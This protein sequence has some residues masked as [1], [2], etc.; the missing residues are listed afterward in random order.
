[1]TDLLPANKAA[2]L[3]HKHR[4]R[5]LDE[6]H[7]VLLETTNKYILQACH[8]GRYNTTIN[9]YEVPYHLRTEVSRQLRVI[10]RE[11]GYRTRVSWQFYPEIIVK[12]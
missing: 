10:L 2:E 11:H 6:W 9:L 12:W 5:E 7:E 8:C 1:M 4:K 3:S